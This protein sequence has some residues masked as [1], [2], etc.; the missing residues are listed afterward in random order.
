MVENQSSPSNSN[1]KFITVFLL[2]SMS[3]AI[4]SAYLPELAVAIVILMIGGT[5]A[6]R[7]STQWP[8]IFLI[9]AI[10]TNFMKSAYIP[11]LIVGEFGATLYMVFT[12]LAA[13][14]FGIQIFTRKRR[15][16]LPPGLWFLLFYIAFTTLSLIVVQ[17][18]RLAIGAYVRNLLN[19]IMIFLLVQM[20]TNQQKVHKLMTAL[21]IQAVFVASWGVIAGIRLEIL[22]EPRRS[23]FFWQ[24]YQK[25]DFAA[26]LG[27]VLVLALATFTLAKT[28]RNRLLALILLPLVPI[29]WVFT[30][31]RGGF[32][33]IVV[34][35]SIF[36]VLERNKKL[37]Q[38]SFVAIFIIALFGLGFITF[39]SS[40]A[41]DLAID[42]LYSIVTGESEAERHE[43]TIGVRFELAKA[44]IDV[45]TQ[46]PVLGVGFNQWQFYSP[47][48]TRVYEPQAN[49]FREKGF[50]I[51]NRYLRI[52]ANSGLIALLGYLGFLIVILI[53]ALKQRH[54][55]N[56]TIRTYLNVFIAAV[57]GIQVALIFAPNVLWEWP[58][59]GILLGLININQTMQK[60]SIL[61]Q[62][63]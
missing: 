32:L 14:G 48:T 37:L 42:G 44:A 17:D 41:R 26:Y 56:I 60:S 38:Q 5:V 35:L 2:L 58:V 1:I 62:A 54:S 20:L 9:L 11:G 59:F 10:W 18:F 31:S 12:S 13:L 43:K 63:V 53:F 47:I 29:G 22:G 57:L 6:I 21:L 55:A 30:F 45:I 7:I 4:I 51:H 3:I 40:N 46:H 50:D 61:E 15:L 49:E 24:Q 23:L 33:A 52:A 16:I 36:L 34:C 8:E 39:S 25:N 27:I 19:W 28:R